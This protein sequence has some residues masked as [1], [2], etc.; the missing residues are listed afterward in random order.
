MLQQWDLIIYVYILDL[1]LS[2]FRSHGDNVF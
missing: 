1:E 2:F